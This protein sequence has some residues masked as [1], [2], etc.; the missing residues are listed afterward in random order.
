MDEEYDAILLGTGLKVT[1][2]DDGHGRSLRTH[3]FG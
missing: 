1:G 2:D 3:L